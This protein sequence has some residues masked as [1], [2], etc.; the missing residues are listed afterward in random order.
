MSH[1]DIEDLDG[2]SDRFGDMDAHWGN[3]KSPPSNLDMKVPKPLASRKGS[4]IAKQTHHELAIK[5]FASMEVPATGKDLDRGEEKW[6]DTT[7]L[8]K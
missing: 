8:D 6:K 3:P 4:N 1:D 5:R 2:N 7:S